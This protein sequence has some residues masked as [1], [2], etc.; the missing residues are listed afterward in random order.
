M[1]KIIVQAYVTLDGYIEDPKDQEMKWV[2]SHF[3]EEM[4]NEI[5]EWVNGTDTILMGRKTYEIFSA[6]WPT[7]TAKKTDP[8]MYDH[9]NNSQKIV[10]SK[11]LQNVRWKNSKLI[12]DIDV[13]EIKNL[14]QGAGKDITISGS[15]SI[16]QALANL[17]LIDRY[18]LM[19]HPLAFGDGKP[20]FKNL[21]E[22]V[23]LSLI[24]S[25]EFK[26]GVVE[27]RYEVLT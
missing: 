20:L 3:S 27:L 10:F 17:N 19:L 25:K 4:V 26:N 8:V 12:R 5:A 22:K 13:E 1:R 18:Y 2:T 6:Y 15:A 9:I 23:K 16:V 21:K 7:E 14:K 24:E 11:T